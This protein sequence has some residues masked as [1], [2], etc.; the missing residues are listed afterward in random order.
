VVWINP[1][2]EGTWSNTSST[3]LIK[4][5]MTDRMYPLTIKGIEESMKYLA[6]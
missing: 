6:R 3:L 2:R 5:V 4:Q 1:E